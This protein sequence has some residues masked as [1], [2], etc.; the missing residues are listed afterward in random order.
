MRGLVAALAVLLC[1]AGGWPLAT[2]PQDVDFAGYDVV[3]MGEVHDNPVHHANQADWV[4]RLSPTA[5]VFE[6]LTPELA[7]KARP[8]VMDNAALADLFQWEQRGWPDFGMYA[9][10]FRAAPKAAVIGGDVPAAQLRTALREGAAAAF[11]EAAPLFALN[12]PLPRPESEA[13]EALQAEAHCNALPTEILPGMVE[14]QRLR[15]AAL[16]QGVV[17][18]LLL[19]G[20]PVAVITGNGHA[21]TDWGLPAALRA[22]L[23]DARV[24]SIGQFETPPDFDPLHD[25]FTLTAAPPRSGDPC[26]VF[27]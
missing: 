18:G 7:D 24:L 21:R 17:A 19:T 20:G 26:D 27:R 5:V 23:P 16:A 4:A 14:A 11:G 6:M 2:A 10:I 8:A 12:R 9:P 13:R 25:L 1:A 15:D 22:A 3:I